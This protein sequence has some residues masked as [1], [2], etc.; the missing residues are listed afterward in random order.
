MKK[1]VMILR[2]MPGSGKS[3]VAKQLKEAA[4]ATV[5]SLDDFRIVDG[6]YK[7]IPAREREVVAAY[8]DAFQA[9]LDREDGF[10]VVD[11]CNSREWEF[12]Q[13]WSKAEDRGYMVHIIEVQA[14]IEECLERQSHPIPVD[15]MQEIFSRW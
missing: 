7:F 6:E 11:N 14:E 5:V 3:E 15:K 8:K 4:G 2:G 12:V 13:E 9:A 1:T 10:I